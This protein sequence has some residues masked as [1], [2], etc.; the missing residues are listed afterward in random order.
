MPEN[1]DK[2][3]QAF[4]Y[5]VR[6]LEE[7]A[8]AG[9]T[10]VELKREEQGLMVIYC[11]KSMGR[12]EAPIPPD[13]EET[14][15]EEI[16][17]RA[18]LADKFKGVISVVLLGKDYHVVVD[19]NHN[20]GESEFILTLKKGKHTATIPSSHG[21]NAMSQMLASPMFKVGDRVR[22]KH[23]VADVDYPDI[24]MG[25]WVGRI[26]KTGSD[27]YLIRWGVETLENV[28]PV[29]RKR[30]E[31]DGIDIEEYWV[32]VDDLELAPIEPLN[33]EQPTAI[34]TEPLSVDSQVAPMVEEAPPPARQRTGGNDPCPCGSG[35]KFKK[36]CLNKGRQGGLF[37]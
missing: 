13:M 10:A 26:S 20:W 7:A 5:I 8:T 16:V 2:H 24:P 25:G 1:A 34:I 3:E 12:A 6:L 15:I 31:R 32:N 30:C 9:A 18:G 33:M 29:Y 35:K 19:L 36:C 37:D 11:F 21:G 22:V 23:G 28:H 27:S 14:V 17:T 4:Q